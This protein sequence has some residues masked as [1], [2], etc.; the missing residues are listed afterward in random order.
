MWNWQVAAL[1]C[2]ASIYYDG[3]PLYPEID[4]LLK[5]CSQKKFTLFGVGA[6]YLDHFKK[7]KI[8]IVNILI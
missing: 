2:G 8:I 7:M 6:K 1:S 5:Y 4:I 3:S